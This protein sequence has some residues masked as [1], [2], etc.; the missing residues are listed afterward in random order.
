MSLINDFTGLQPPIYQN[1]QNYATSWSIILAWIPN[2][3]EM[4]LPGGMKDGM[5]IRSYR[6]ELDSNYICS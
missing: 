4:F 6:V 2:W 3:L 1:L 5:S